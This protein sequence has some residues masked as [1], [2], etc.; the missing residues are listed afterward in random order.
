MTAMGTP[1]A[2]TAAQLAEE[3]NSPGKPPMTFQERIAL[4]RQEK[5]EG[6]SPG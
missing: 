4:E 2:G 5:G 1:K 3:V 6:Q